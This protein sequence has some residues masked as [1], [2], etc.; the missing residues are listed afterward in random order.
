NNFLPFALPDIGEPEIEE[1]CDSLR[2]G[3]LTTG[4]KAKQFESD[5]AAFISVKHAMAVNSATSGLHLALEAIGV[6]P[7]DKVLT[8]V[9]TFTASAEVIR[10][11]G[12][13][14]VFVDIDAETLN[15]DVGKARE[16]LTAEPKAKAIMPVHV[17][18]QACDMD[19]IADLA[20]SYDLKVV[21]DAAHALP[22]TYKGKTIGSLSDAT[23]FSF[24]VT[25][26]I[27]TG[28]GGM[29]VT[30]DEEIAA[31]I[32]T[33]R[34]HGISKDA[35]DRYSSERPSWYYEV[36][37]PGFKYNMPDIAAAIGIHQ[38]RKVRE[39]RGRRLEIADMYRAAFRDLPIT[40]PTQVIP[41]DEHS[42]HLFVIQLNLDEITIDRD[43]FIE[44]MSEEKIGTSVHFIPLHMQPY[45]RDKYRLVPEDF[46]VASG[47][48]QRIVSLPIYSKMSDTDV[49]RVVKAVRKI[50][51]SNSK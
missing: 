41:T 29:V 47:V 10:Y 25:K 11:L 44:L 19:G 24:Y 5:F 45:W 46:P 8:T 39:M 31:R 9:N 1:V 38:L 49:G 43:R 51:I 35:F 26:T 30:N 12:A 14:P 27:A 42:W 13:D 37:A 28:E 21:E 20:D 6:G 23:V 17:A 32:R 33:M 34:L 3:W 18:G 7:G 4:P 40:L 2:S 22:T 48:F 15:I 16:I 36:V 50:I